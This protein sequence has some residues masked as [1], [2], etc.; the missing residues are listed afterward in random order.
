MRREDRRR[1]AGDRGRVG[2]AILTI[3]IL[4]SSATAACT[5]LL[6]CMVPGTGRLDSVRRA[7]GAVMPERAM[8]WLCGAR[9]RSPPTGMP[10]P[11]GERADRT[12]AP[13]TFIFPS[14]GIRSPG[15]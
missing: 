11:P 13:V 14:C 5:R 3:V 4:A 6:G 12:A 9:P 10:T 2:R 8:A 1:E 7:V 15:N